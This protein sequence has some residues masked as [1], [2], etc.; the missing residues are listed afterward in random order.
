MIENIIRV[1]IPIIGIIAAIISAAVSYYFTKRDQIE[2]EE[3]RLKEKYYLAFIK[4]VSDLVLSDDIDKARRSL[5]DALNQLLLVASSDV[6]NNLML[7]FD[8]LK[9]TNKKGHGFSS[10]EHDRL[11]TNL[12]KSM[13]SDLYKNEKTNVNYPIIQLTGLN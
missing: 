10:E 6:V 8:Y 3:R 1:A 2:V 7:F 4:A 11:L 5:A 9:A 13:R 12:I